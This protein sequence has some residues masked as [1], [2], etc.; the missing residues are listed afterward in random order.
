M[1]NPF[2]DQSQISHIWLT[3]E[4]NL[5]CGYCR[6]VRDTPG[7]KP[8]ADYEKDELQAKHWFE[9]IKILNKLGSK[10]FLMYGAEPLRYKG[11]GE[12]LDLL[13][14]TDIHYSVHS[15]GTLQTELDELISKRPLKGLTLSWDPTV[16]DRSVM[17]KTNVAKKL[18]LKYKEQVPDLTVTMTLL[19]SITEGDNIERFIDGVQ[20]FREQGIWCSITVIDHARNEHYD[21]SYVPWTKEN[22]IQV[23]PRFMELVHM[24]KTIYADG[25]LIH[26]N[27]E[28]FDELEETTSKENFYCETPWAFNVIDADGS[29]R[30][31][32]R[33][34]G[35][36][37]PKYT[38]KDMIDKPEEVMAAFKDDYK[39]MCIGCSWDCAAQA[40]VHRRYPDKYTKEDVDKQFTH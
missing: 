16:F 22:K 29:L 38:P 23:N 21:F 14:Q 3:R 39:N 19:P 32:N 31:C 11:L 5:S 18:F 6:V 26:N 10:F 4:C 34:K 27:P 1:S 37:L 24:L 9:N 12:L 17:G 30:M 28:W 15:N 7:L 25:K 2:Q 33:I 36:K 35:N 20:W 13:N 8:V 40:T